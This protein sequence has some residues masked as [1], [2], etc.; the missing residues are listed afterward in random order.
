MF[1]NVDIQ[2]QLIRFRNKSRKM[3]DNLISEANRILQNDLFAEKKILENLKQ[4]NKAFEKL[5]EEDIDDDLIFTPIEI[6][7][8]SVIY[9]LKFLDSKLYKPEIPYEA[10]LKIKEL[11]EKFHKE[12][13]FFKI[14]APHSG[15]TE[16][17][18]V[19]D[20][21]LF[22]AT[23]YDNYYLIHRWGKQ[24]KWDRKFKFWP[25]RNFE[26]LVLTVVV[27]TLIITMSL[28]TALITLDPKAE[29]WSG[30]RAAA[31]FHLLIFNFGVTVYVTFAF[32]K[33]LS[34]SVWNRYRDFD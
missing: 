32:A 11:N 12:I 30:Y 24:L 16:K 6:K 20:S 10:V 17:E 18:P 9:R 29:Y 28:P 33:N 14:L 23:N 27:T 5:D 15:F 34:S 31:F 2:N 8:I 7:Q 1:E 22:A 21:L 26:T 25:L 3:E 13:K 4:Y 19:Y